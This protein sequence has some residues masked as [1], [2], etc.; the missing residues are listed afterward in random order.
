[1]TLLETQIAAR[2]RN[3][4]LL[5]NELDRYKGF[6]TNLEKEGFVDY[7]GRNMAKAKFEQ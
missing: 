5:R 3:I 6:V 4:E 2:Q 1:M 7:I